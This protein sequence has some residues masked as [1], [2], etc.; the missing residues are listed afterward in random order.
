ME[1]AVDVDC[2]LASAAEVWNSDWKDDT[3][4]LTDTAQEHPTSVSERC[5]HAVLQEQFLLKFHLYVY[6]SE[7]VL[8]KLYKA[9]KNK[10]SAK[11]SLYSYKVM[12]W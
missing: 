5:K 9:K 12:C 10:T 8:V 4:S 3:T 11:Y 2:E 6:A 7:E 1:A